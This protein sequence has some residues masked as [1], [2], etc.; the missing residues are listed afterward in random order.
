MTSVIAGE[1][2]IF[3]GI[4]LLSIAKKLL[5]CNTDCFQLF[6]RDQEAYPGDLRAVQFNWHQL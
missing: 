2:L 4:C 6:G 5:Y 1:P 3:A